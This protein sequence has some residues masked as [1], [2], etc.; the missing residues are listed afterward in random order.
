MAT[1][2]RGLFDRTIRLC[3]GLV[4]GF[5]SGLTCQQPDDS[6]QRLF[7]LSIDMRPG[8]RATAYTA[9]S[10]SPPSWRPVP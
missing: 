9:R 10:R 5:T 3:D 6:K 2:I 1:F 4:E 7:G 8:T